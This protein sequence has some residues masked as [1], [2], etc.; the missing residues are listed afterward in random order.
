MEKIAAFL[1]DYIISSF[2]DA[3]TLCIYEYNEGWN[4]TKSI[5][6]DGS[7]LNSMKS[8]RDYYFKLTEE[9]EDCKI[10]IVNKAIGT[11]YSIFYKEDFSIWELKGNPLDYFEM[12][13]EKENQHNADFEEEKE[14]VKKLVRFKGDGYYEIDL[15]EIQNKKPDLSS[16]MIIKPFLEKKDFKVLEIHCCHTPPWL[17]AESE[18][19]Y[20]NMQREVIDK[21]TE[22]LYIK[23][24]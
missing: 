14:E 1:N 22:I 7:H 9:L 15:E 4:L 5:K 24:R 11:P 6:I 19:G 17:I 10:I 13:I 23:G 3:D 2:Q 21:N 8:I 20:I 18:A 16:K 12:I